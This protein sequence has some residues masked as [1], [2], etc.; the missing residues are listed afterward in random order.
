MEVE[1]FDKEGNEKGYMNQYFLCPICKR[2]N[3]TYEDAKNCM[4]ECVYEEYG[5]IEEILEDIE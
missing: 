4:E 3:E 5:Q 2:K 1:V